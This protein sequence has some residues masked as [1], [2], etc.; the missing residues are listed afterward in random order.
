[1][2]TARREYA[3]V[4]LLA[5]VRSYSTVLVALLAGHPDLYGFPEML[6]FSSPD[7][8]GLMSEESRRPAMP[9]S[10]LRTRRTGILRAIADLH[11]GCQD[12]EAIA[13]A[14]RWLAGRPDWSTIQLMDYLLDTARP[15]TG[16]EK[17]PDTTHSA[18]TL[19][20]CVS[21]Y[22][23]AR[24][25]HLTR[26]PVTTQRSMHEHQGRLGRYDEQEL[27][28]RSA[29]VWYLTHLRIA[30]RL[31]ALPRDRWLRVRA[32]DVLRDPDTWLRVLCQWLGLRCEAG[33]IAQMR[34]TE[35][36]RF[37]GT[38]ANGD[39]GGGD[40]KFLHSPVLRSVPDPGPVAFD[41]GWG[42]PPGM[43]SRMIRLASLLGY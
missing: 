10:W 24:F 40:P 18:Q 9:S 13:R 21:A 31:A 30:K 26:H 28:V 33:I 3:P 16:V 34:H 27:I 37:A 38:G 22:P 25:I 12:P 6:L 36:W 43:T 14:E 7:V 32:E 1:M 17:S 19:D 20:A 41:T 5:P 11:E 15:R 35:R 39:L 29:S 8:R 2:S 4:F 23:G 42:L